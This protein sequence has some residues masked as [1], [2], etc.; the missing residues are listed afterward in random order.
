MKK[1]AEYL[2]KLYIKLFQGP[3]SR[4]VHKDIKGKGGELLKM[5]RKDRRLKEQCERLPNE[6][7]Q[8][9]RRRCFGYNPLTPPPAG[10]QRLGENKPTRTKF[11][12]TIPSD[13]KKLQKHL[14][15]IKNNFM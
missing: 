2:E 5:L 8:D 14:K 7:E 9:Y 15:K 13:I 11:N 10:L 6:S 3:T 12:L 1:E 4:M